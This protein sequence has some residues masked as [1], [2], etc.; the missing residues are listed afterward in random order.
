M[1]SE[2]N[3]RTM[4]NPD[5]LRYFADAFDLNLSIP[6]SIRTEAYK[7]AAHALR[8]QAA[9]VEGAWVISNLFEG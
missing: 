5:A 3:G 8:E 9:R 1:A 7:A 6:S 2:N 4:L